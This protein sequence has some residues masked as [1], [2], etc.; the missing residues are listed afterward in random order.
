MQRFRCFSHFRIGCIVNTPQPPKLLDQMRD[1]IRRKHF[2]YSTEE[3]YVQWARRYILFHNKRH[4][5]EMAE[6]E[7]RAFLTHLAVERSVAASTQNQ[8]LNA[9]VF[10]YEH[11][12][13]HPLGDFSNA[14]RAKRP[15]RLP[16]V[17]TQDEVRQILAGMAGVPRLL[18]EL[19]YGAGLRVNEGLSLRIKD[20]D[21][22]GRQLIIRDAKGGKDRVSILPIRVMDPLKQHLEKVKLLWQADQ[23]NK[24]AGVYLPGAL[25]KKYPQAGK[26]WAW[27]WVFPSPTLSH[28]PRSKVKRR[29]H[30]FVTSIQRAFKQ[31]VKLTML[32]KPATPHTLRHSFATHLLEA[33]TDIRTVQTLLGHADVSTTMIYTHVMQK[34]GPATPSP[35]DSL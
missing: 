11:V 4:P 17:L 14:E 3:A 5:R 20:V 22:P 32:D 7:I 19:L 34:R 13:Q 18:A 28:D 29:H 21:F 6:N 1:A 16:C 25:E 31:A 23:R 10:L 9:L 33:G 24:V 26:E 8:A 35:L 30:L 27:Q 12:L 2:A 15:A